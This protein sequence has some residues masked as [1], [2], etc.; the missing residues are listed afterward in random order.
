LILLVSLHWINC[1]PDFSTFASIFS[2][3]SPVFS[4]HFRRFSLHFYC[5]SIFLPFRKGDI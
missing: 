5:V 1:S 3:F 4:S 2:S